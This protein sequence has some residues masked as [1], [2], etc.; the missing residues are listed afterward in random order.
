[1]S[2]A[3]R[4]AGPLLPGFSPP[5]SGQPGPFAFADPVRVRHVL[6]ESGWTGVTIAAVDAVCTMQEKDL[7]P[8][9]T[10]MGPVGRM[11]STVD[12]NTRVRVVEA[13]AEGHA[14]FVTDGEVRYTAA[15]WL[16]SAASP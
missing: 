13:L 3:E 12:E 1:M 10:Q 14:Q 7:M 16:V 9:L 8:Y 11:L 4:V 2:T 15:C 5:T 6:E